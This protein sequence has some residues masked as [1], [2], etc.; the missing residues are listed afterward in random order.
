M[1][2]LERVTGKVF[3]S[4]FG[5]YPLILCLRAGAPF[6][7]LSLGKDEVRGLVHSFNEDLGMRGAP[8]SLVFPGFK[9]VATYYHLIE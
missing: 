8:E 6:E 7:Q 4:S 2:E 9:Q 1:Y 5:S 3:G